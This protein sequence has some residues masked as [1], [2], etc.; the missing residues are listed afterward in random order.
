MATL[1]AAQKRAIKKMQAGLKKWRAC[2]KKKCSTKKKTT[3]KKTTRRAAPVRKKVM[4]KKVARKKVARKKV[5]RKRRTN[6][7]LSRGYVIAALIKQGTSHRVGYLTGSAVV[8][9]AF[10]T[11]AKALRFGD[12]S[13]AKGVLNTVLKVSAIKRKVV[14]AGVFSSNKSESSIKDALYNAL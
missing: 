13:I 3:R 2:G 7:V 4:R 9:K 12:L 10:S 14:V 11:R 8:S 1:S 6:P 5:A